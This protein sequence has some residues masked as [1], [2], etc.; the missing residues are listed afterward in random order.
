MRTQGVLARNSAICY[1]RAMKIKRGVATILISLTLS[2]L[3][4]CESMTGVTQSLEKLNKTLAPL[5]VI[6]E[7]SGS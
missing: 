7:G 2:V 3:G 1:D 5:A 6:K 4:G